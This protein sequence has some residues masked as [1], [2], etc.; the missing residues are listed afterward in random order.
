MNRFSV[1]FAVGLASLF[2]S[3]V[4]GEEHKYLKAF[5]QASEGM[6]RFV[7]E[8]PNKERGEDSRFKVEI[9][10]GKEMSTDGVNM[11]RLGA[12]IEAKPLEGWGFTYYEV[13]KF[14]PGASTLMAVPPGT[15]PEIKF[16]STSKIIPYNSRIPI[17]VYVPKGGEVRYRI[18]E[19]SKTIQKGSR[20]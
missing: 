18:W 1:L 10:V 4:M 8:L 19:A 20:G 14:G 5:P 12:T 9:M 15:K 3:P 17:V 7:I 16:V 6:E 2:S 13:K 11:V